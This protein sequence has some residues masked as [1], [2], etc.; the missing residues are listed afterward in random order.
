M[1]N[2]IKIILSLF[3]VNGL[4]AM[5]R[6][7]HQSLSNLRRYVPG[8]IS[9]VSNKAFITPGNPIQAYPGGANLRGAKR[10][11][12]YQNPQRRLALYKKLK[13]QESLSK[14]SNILSTIRAYDK[15]IQASIKDSFLGTSL[16]GVGLMVSGRSLYDKYMTD[17][18][19]KNDVKNVESQA[20]S[21]V[22]GLVLSKS[23]EEQQLQSGW[24]GLKDSIYQG[25]NAFTQR[26]A[27]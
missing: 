17:G 22:A 27:K 26:F 21:S 13:E 10:L 19:A 12:R 14:E 25:W 20:P 24:T 2:K 7:G 5:S 8:N 9:S 15:K 16:L 3:L 23:P 18:K 6:F 11:I 1:N 4:L